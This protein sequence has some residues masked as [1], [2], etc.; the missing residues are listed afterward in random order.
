MQGIDLGNPLLI[1]VALCGLC[2]VGIVVLVVLQVLGGALGLIG[3]LFEGV[4]EL[5]N[6][7]PLA[8]CGCLVGLALLLGCGGVIWLIV[9]SLA[10]CGTENAVNLCAWLGR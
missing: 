8:W 2:I 6:A 5:I 3:G 7:G 4:F 10:S 1:I 9:S